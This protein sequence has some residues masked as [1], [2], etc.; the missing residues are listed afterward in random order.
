[1][2]I[3]L[4]ET[5][6]DETNAQLAAEF[7]GNCCTGFAAL[8][9]VNT[10]SGILIAWDTDLITATSTIRRN[11]TLTM[12]LSLNLSNTTFWITRVYGPTD[13]SAKAFFLTELCNCQPPTTIPWICLGDFNLICEEGDKNNDNI[14]RRQIREFRRALDASELLEIKLINRRYTWSNGRFNPTLV[15]LDRV[16]CNKDWDNLFP[17]LSLLALSS[18]LSDHCPLVLCNHQLPPR[19][20]TFRFEQFWVRSPEFI[21]IVQNAWQ[22]QA[23]GVS[24]LM[25]LH[26][27]LSN[28]AAALR[29]WSRSLVSNA[30]LQFSIANEVIRRLESAQETRSLNAAE[31][32]L[33]RDLKQ[34]VRGWAAIERSR[35]R[36]CLRLIQLKEGDACTRYFHQRAKGRRRKNLIAYIKTDDGSLRWSHEEKEVA[37]HQYFTGIL[38]TKV[39][40]GSSFDW[41]R[42]NLP[43]IDDPTM[44]AEFSLEE[45]TNTIKEMPSEKAPA[46][47]L[48]RDFLQ[49]VL[50]FDSGRYHGCYAMFL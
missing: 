1:M 14:N 23:V 3:C 17:Q 34:Q 22:Q 50:A 37:V 32:Q 43:R 2:L 13:N 48:H 35:R 21:E 6:L 4:Q 18:S 36:Q 38:G 45:M 40:R 15:L 25:I 9:V 27:R 26:N 11:Y 41:E 8:D 47:W 5:K 30:S 10:C 28:T 24:P 33:I 20:A 12:E 16:F 46:G 39:N 29:H 49:K 7:L 42:L 31:C 19:R 44:D